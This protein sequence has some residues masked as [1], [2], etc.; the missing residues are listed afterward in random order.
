MKVETMT[1]VDAIRRYENSDNIFINHKKDDGAVILKVKPKS[2]CNYSRYI[3]DS[4]IHVLTYLTADHEMIPVYIPRFNLTFY[5]NMI[6][7]D[8]D[9]GIIVIKSTNIGNS[10]AKTLYSNAIILPFEY[11][12]DTFDITEIKMIVKSV[13]I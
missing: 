5:T 4:D 3:I 11:E 9:N 10:D 12:S 8:Y 13:P 6:Q 7:F 2:G 1:F